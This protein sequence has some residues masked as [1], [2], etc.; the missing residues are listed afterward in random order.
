MKNIEAGDIITTHSGDGLALVL[1]ASTVETESELGKMLAHINMG[2][3]LLIRDLQTGEMR[4]SV[5]ESCV[6]RVY[7]LVELNR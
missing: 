7:K 4:Y 3:T 6:D 2:K 5:H 1:E